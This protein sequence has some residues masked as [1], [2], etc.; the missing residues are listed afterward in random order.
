MNN[1]RLTF[2]ASLHISHTGLEIH[3][4][5]HLDVRSRQLGIRIGGPLAVT[6]QNGYFAV[7]KKSS[8]THRHG[9]LQCG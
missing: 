6:F 2:T 4:P 7:E 9:P 3:R 8:W 1:E 5:D